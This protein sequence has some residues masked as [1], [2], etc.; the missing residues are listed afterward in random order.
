M[1]HAISHTCSGKRASSNRRPELAQACIAPYESAQSNG[2]SSG[3]CSH[4]RRLC[5]CFR[6][7]LF[8]SSPIFLDLPNVTSISISPPRSD[9]ATFFPIRP[10]NECIEARIF[11]P[12]VRLT[13]RV[14]LWDPVE[15]AQ[16]SPGNSIQSSFYFYQHSS[17]V[18]FCL[19]FASTAFVQ[20]SY[21]QDE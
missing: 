19:H 4:V 2:A 21:R 20:R 10:L 7:S 6:A 13:P 5:G 16:K 18:L 9:L 11:K 15:A 12:L 14:S 3:F 17:F 8:Q 1:G